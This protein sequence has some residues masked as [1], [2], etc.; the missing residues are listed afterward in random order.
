[1]CSLV[2]GFPISGHIFVRLIKVV[3]AAILYFSLLNCFS[4][5]RHTLVYLQT[6]AMDVL[7]GTL[8]IGGHPSLW[9]LV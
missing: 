6:L 7:L 1:M 2:C 5:S 9:S 3:H 4:P 8:H